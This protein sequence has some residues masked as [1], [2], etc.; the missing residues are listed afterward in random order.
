MKKGFKTS[1]FGWRD[2]NQTGDRNH[3][4]AE[5]KNLIEKHIHGWNRGEVACAND[6]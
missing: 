5:E 2:G 1:L 4:N 3:E 6:N